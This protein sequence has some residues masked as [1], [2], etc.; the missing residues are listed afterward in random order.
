MKQN[1]IFIAMFDRRTS[2]SFTSTKVLNVQ[3]VGL[4]G[5]LRA[6]IIFM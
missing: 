4:K 3:R 1:L 2:V 6:Q 5:K